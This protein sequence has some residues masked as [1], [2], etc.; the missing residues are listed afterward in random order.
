LNFLQGQLQ[1]AVDTEKT[2]ESRLLALNGD[3]AVE[4]DDPPHHDEIGKEEPP[5]NNRVEV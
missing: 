3:T 1:A 2:E 4:K 5:G